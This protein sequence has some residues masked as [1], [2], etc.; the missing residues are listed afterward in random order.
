[1]TQFEL[2]VDFL[3]RFLNPLCGTERDHIPGGYTG[4]PTPQAVCMKMRERVHSPGH[5][6]TLVIRK[7]NEYQVNV[8]KLWADVLI[9][10]GTITQ[11]AIAETQTAGYD[12]KY[13]Q[14]LEK[15]NT[16]HGIKSNL[17]ESILLE[18]LTLFHVATPAQMLAHPGQL[19]HIVFSVISQFVPLN[20]VNGTPDIPAI[21]QS[22][23]HNSKLNTIHLTCNVV[24]KPYQRT[25]DFVQSP[26]MA[27][28]S[29]D[30]LDQS[31]QSVR[32]FPTT[33]EFLSKRMIE[34]AAAFAAPA[35]S[36]PPASAPPLH[37]LD[38][39]KKTRRRT[40]K[41]RKHSNKGR[42]ALGGLGLRRSFGTPRK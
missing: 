3:N 5:T 15:W 19:S 26:I 35:H 27:Y 10:D 31:V 13:G 28:L 16:R 22:D 18:L 29:S 33:V 34:K 25:H 17:D 6:W 36:A 32:H 41:K 14:L 12:V 23:K 8:L 40:S 21:P 4:N 2:C 1:M 9:R 20:V 37:E 11:P 42:H 38:G 30:V 7:I 39:G 24:A